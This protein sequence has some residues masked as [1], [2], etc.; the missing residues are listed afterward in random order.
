MTGK[1]ILIYQ[2]FL[3]S[4]NTLVLAGQKEEGL[5]FMQHCRDLFE[6]QNRHGDAQ[7]AELLIEQLKNK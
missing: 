7:K 5:N 3:L 4:C 2:R 6:Q 1:T